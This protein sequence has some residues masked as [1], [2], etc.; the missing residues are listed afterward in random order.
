MKVI[1]LLAAIQDRN[2]DEDIHIAKQTEHGHEILFAELVAVE[3]F[4]E[5]SESEGPI[6]VLSGPESS[7]F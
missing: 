4:D 1:E 2:E 6:L 7:S 5:N 3:E